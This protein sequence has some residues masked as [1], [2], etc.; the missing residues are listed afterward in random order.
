MVS[1]TVLTTSKTILFRRSNVII[2][3]Y[4]Y[5]QYSRNLSTQENVAKGARGILS[6]LDGE[7]FFFL[8]SY[9]IR[10]YWNFIKKLPNL[11]SSRLWKADCIQC[12]GT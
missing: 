2:S 6:K 11:Y 5:G 1:T 3:R 8:Y 10:L 9:F 7:Y 4:S 12:K